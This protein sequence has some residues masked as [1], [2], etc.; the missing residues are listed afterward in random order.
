[1]F[2]H[3]QQHNWA[4]DELGVMRLC[5]QIFASALD[6]KRT[7]EALRERLRFEALLSSLSTRLIDAPVDRIDSVITDT[8]PV[9]GQAQRVGRVSV[10]LLDDKRERFLPN[11]EWCAE[12]VAS[13]RQS[14]T[15]LPIAQFGWPLEQ[16]A[17]GEAML[18][19]RDE[20]LPDA[21]MARMVM[22]RDGFE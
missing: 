13:F 17:A 15:G 6:R 21:K 3:D 9:V 18:I 7:D 19:L 22:A 11:Y 16:I 4:D 12:G 2:V 20:I 14:M 8:L 10:Q 1:A 5:A